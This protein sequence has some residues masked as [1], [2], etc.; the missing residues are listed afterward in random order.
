MQINLKVA[1]VFFKKAVLKHFAILT[2][3]FNQFSDLQ[4]NTS[5]FLWIL[6]IFKSNYF[7]EHLRTAASEVRINQAWN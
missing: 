4:V 1:E 7:E 6:Q 2:N 3:V 5:V